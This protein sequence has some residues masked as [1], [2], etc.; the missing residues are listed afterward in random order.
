MTDKKALFEFKDIHVQVEGKEVV[1]GVSLKINPGETH[2]IMGPNGSGKSSLS[3]A[4]MGHPSYEITGGEIYLD[5]TNMRDLTADER[6]RA[7]LFLA[8]QYPLAIPGVTVANFLRT[9]LQAHRGKEADMSDFRRLLKTEMKALSIDEVF[10][11]R[12]LNDGFSGGEKKRIEILQMSILNPRMAILDET[13]SGLDIDAL[14]T[15][16][17]GINRYHNDRNGILLVTHYQRILNYVKPDFVHVMMAGKI[18]K[19]GGPEIALKLE[20]LG[21]DWVAEEVNH[22]AGV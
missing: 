6:S 5:G 8:F 14:K 17:E 18:V 12:Y 2:A 22:K 7:G 21:Y 11:T 16:S 9:A 10:A 13:D 15:V 4:L 3:N 1:S 20:D 19:S